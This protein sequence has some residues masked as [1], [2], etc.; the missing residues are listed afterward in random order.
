MIKKID[1]WLRLFGF[2]KRE[3][4]IKEKMCEAAK[5]KCQQYKQEAREATNILVK[6]YELRTGIT[7]KKE[8][9]NHAS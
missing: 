5:D 6:E 8:V 1:Y 9:L 3:K 4:T 7:V 2:K